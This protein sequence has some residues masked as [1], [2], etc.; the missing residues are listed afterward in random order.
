[1]SD[2]A[3]VGITAGAVLLSVLTDS[4]EALY[5]WG[6]PTKENV[7]I[8]AALFDGDTGEMLW[9]LR[10]DVSISLK[11]AETA[12]RQV[13]NKISEHFPYLSKHR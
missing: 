9:Y 11:K 1:M 13:N 6:F 5:D 10:E 4:D 12:V 2:E 3:A 7:F 8:D